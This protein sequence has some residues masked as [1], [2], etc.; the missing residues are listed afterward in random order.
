MTISSIHRPS[1]F[2]LATVLLV[3]T[4]VA[5][6]LVL[7][8]IS[9]VL[10]LVAAVFFPALVRTV[11]VGRDLRHKG[12]SLAAADVI[13]LFTALLYV[14]VLTLLATCAV[15]GVTA[16]A[17]DAALSAWQAS[18]APTAVLSPVAQFAA[19]MFSLAI[20]LLLFWWS[21]FLRRSLP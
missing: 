9:L 14:S 5:V 13:E 20:Y 15:L 7:V 6:W 2:S 10:A 1:Q 4:L 18:P 11:M 19:A 17:L 21:T 3:I 12:E 16:C 8:R